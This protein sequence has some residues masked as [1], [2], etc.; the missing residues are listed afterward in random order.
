MKY[1]K[2]EIT[3]VDSTSIKSGWDFI[4]DI[5][6]EHTEIGMELMFSIGYLLQNTK[7]NV[8]ICQSLHLDPKKRKG[9]DR[10]I[11]YFSIP[12]GCI[13]KIEYL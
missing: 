6:N 3:W 10:A 11:E 4:E 9:Y 2:V 7:D 12:K 8:V 1:K 13:K 5:I